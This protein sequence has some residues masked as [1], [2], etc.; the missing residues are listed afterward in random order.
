MAAED[1]QQIKLLTIGDSGV[2]KSWLLLRWAGEAGKLSKNSS[3]MPTIGIDF[4]MKLLLLIINVLKF[5]F[6]ILLVKRGLE[7]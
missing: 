1:P 7:L 4:K 5:K 6:G 2:G 3:S